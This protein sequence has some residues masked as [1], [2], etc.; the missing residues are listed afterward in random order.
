MLCV[1]LVL[2]RNAYGEKLIVWA[3]SVFQGRIRP[4]TYGCVLRTCTD[5][6]VPVLR[7]YVVSP[8][9]AFRGGRFNVGIF[10]YQGVWKNEE[11]VN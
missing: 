11:V 6:I 8:S 10:F 5:Y 1:R 9:R 2:W 7:D 4:E 3:S